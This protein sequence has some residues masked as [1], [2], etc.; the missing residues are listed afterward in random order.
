MKCKQVHSLLLSQNLLILYAVVLSYL[1]NRVMGFCLKQLMLCKI[2][3]KVEI[4]TT[5]A[6]HELLLATSREHA[7][8]T[9]RAKANDNHRSH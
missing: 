6:L 3:T 4:T 9:S 2:T 1:K 7:P 5:A 8:S